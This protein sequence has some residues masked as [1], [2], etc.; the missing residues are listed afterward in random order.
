MNNKILFNNEIYRLND[1]GHTA[2]IWSYVH[3]GWDGTD[4]MDKSIKVTTNTGAWTLV[5]G[6]GGG[7][8]VQA[9]YN[10]NDSTAADYIKNRPF[11]EETSLTEIVNF[12]VISGNLKEAGSTVTVEYDG[13]RAT[14][15]VTDAG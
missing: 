9:D 8:S 15:V 2:G 13:E 1:P 5:M 10:Q 11:Y 3:T 12:K 6:Q 7:S 14:G 4:V